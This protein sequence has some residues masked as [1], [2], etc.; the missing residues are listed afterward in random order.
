[1]KLILSFVIFIKLTSNIATIPLK[2]ILA[3]LAI[4][5]MILA[6][7]HALS[8]RLANLTI[9][10]K[11]CTQHTLAYQKRPLNR[12]VLWMRLKKQ[13]STEQQVWYYKDTSLLKGSSIGLNCSAL[14]QQKS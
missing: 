9:W 14:H 4:I 8:L 6:I 5:S 13:R 3:N 1:L 12:A 7:S 2:G 11:I 10:V